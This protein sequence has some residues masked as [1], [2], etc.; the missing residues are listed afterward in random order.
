ML[1]TAT[2]GRKRPRTQSGISIRKTNE[3]INSEAGDRQQVAVEIVI[4]LPLGRRTNE[5]KKERKLV[6]KSASKVQL[7]QVALRRSPTAPKEM[8]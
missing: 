3:T 2:G 1:D 7:M 4:N 5:R 8:S 6:S